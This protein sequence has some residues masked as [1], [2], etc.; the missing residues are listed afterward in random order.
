V[1]HFGQ[2]ALAD[3]PLPDSLRQPI[4]QRNAWKEDKE[5]DNLPCEQ[6]ETSP[7]PPLK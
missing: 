2:V 3:S 5:E 6:P 7:A 4:A 1:I